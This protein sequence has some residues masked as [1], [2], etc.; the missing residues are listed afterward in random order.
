MAQ[1]APKVL[2]RAFDGWIRA[3]EEAVRLMTEAEQPETPHDWTEGYRWVTRMASMAQEWVIEKSDPMNPVI[4]L[5]QNPYRKL[6]G[7]NPD[8]NYH[9]TTLD[10]QQNYILSGNRGEAPYVGLAFGTDVFRSEE[11]GGGTTLQKSLD[12]LDI[13]ADG[14]FELR[15][16]PDVSGPG[17]LRLP[18]GTSQL[19]V[20]ETF[21]DRKTQ[22]PAQLTI[23]REGGRDA[24]P[25]PSPEALAERME[26]AAHFLLKVTHFCIN[27]YG[28][29]GFMV[30]ELA[31][32]G[33]GE[34]VAEG[35]NVPE[36]GDAENISIR[37]HSDADMAYYG[38]RWK[39][40]EGE[41]LAVTIHPPEQDFVYWGL[42]LLNPWL[43]SY[44]YLSRQTCLNNASAQPNADGSWTMV[45]AA[46]DPGRSNWLDTGGRLEGM[47]L[48]R[49]CLAGQNPPV[50]TCETIKFD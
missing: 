49:W 4:F 38:G 17:S 27:T 43:E 46:S 9:F 13:A 26:T 12:D 36:D 37:S 1:Q 41:G 33:G 45:I 48:L 42:V 21:T 50:P 23:K 11:P 44:D 47:M 20:R 34:H 15:L 30:N 29:S 25:D 8:V 22:R 5:G 32:R 14:S 7:D 24:D 10:C 39:L 16:G 3:Q 40:A 19:N 35:Q 28:L 6:M 2:R 18:P 31:G